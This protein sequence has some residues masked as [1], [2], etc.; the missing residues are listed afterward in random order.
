MSKFRKT[1][2]SLV[3]TAFIGG[4]A[5]LGVGILTN[6]PA[7][8]MT[9]QDAAKASVQIGKYCSG[10]VIED[11]DLSDGEQVTIISAQH[12][13]DGTQ[14]VGTVL[15]INI[16][17]IVGNEYVSDKTVKAIVTSVS[18]KSDLILIQILDAEEG[19]NLPKAKVYGGTPQFGDEVVALGYPFG[20]LRTMT[21]G[22]LGYVENLM[23]VFKTSCVFPSES[24]R[25]QKATPG[26][27]PGSSGG[28][29]FKETDYGYQLIGVLTGGNPRAG[30]V[31]YYTPIDEIREFL[32][33]I[34][35]KVIDDGESS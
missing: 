33:S 15:E 11:P 5:G 12:C 2:S 1:I 23:Y 6:E 18:D 13:L 28:G 14:G 29:L 31:N 19:R 21:T 32:W 8:K 4:A 9:L 27:A 10:T 25:Y 17:N 20:G 26:V 22:V 3:V 7:D 30:F 34:G 16:P 35:N 24:C